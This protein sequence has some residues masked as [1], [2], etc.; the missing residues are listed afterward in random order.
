MSLREVSEV[1]M[2]G[3]SQGAYFTFKGLEEGQVGMSSYLACE[4]LLQ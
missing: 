4:L 1:E 2:G 3:I